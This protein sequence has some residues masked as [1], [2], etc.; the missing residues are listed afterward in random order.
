M[1]RAVELH[2]Q[3]RA[4]HG[5]RRERDRRRR[6]IRQGHEALHMQLAARHPKLLQRRLR[7]VHERAWPADKAL[8][9]APRPHQFLDLALRRR[10]LHAV[11]P[12]DHA[13]PA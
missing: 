11:Q 12:V 6:R 7:R 10:P 8:G 2:G 4:A 13:Q 9:Q 3:R 1:C 5:G